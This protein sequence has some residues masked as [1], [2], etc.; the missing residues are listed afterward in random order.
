MSIFFFLRATIIF[1]FA[2][3][4]YALVAFLRSQAGLDHFDFLVRRVRRIM[5][6]LE[7]AH[8][9]FSCSVM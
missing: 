8:L 1:F 5:L 3:S 4:C 2:L 7:D 6:E 9:F